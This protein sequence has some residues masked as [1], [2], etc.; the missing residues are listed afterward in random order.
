MDITT[1]IENLFCL[2]T[3]CLGIREINHTNSALLIKW[4]SRLMHPPGDLVTRVLALFE[5]PRPFRRV[6]GLCSPRCRP[7]SILA[8]GTA[9]TSIF[10]RTGRGVLQSRFSHFYA[11]VWDRHY[12]TN[13]WVPKARGRLSTPY[14][15]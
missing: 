4:V 9:R 1:V 12:W 2:L 5:G 10:G 8:W 3:K 7:F 13:A 6:F 14:G 11:L 15:S